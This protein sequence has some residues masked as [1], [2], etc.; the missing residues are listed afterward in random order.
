MGTVAIVDDHLEEARALERVLRELDTSV[1]IVLFNNVRD[2]ENASL[3]GGFPEALFVDVQLSEQEGALTG[4]DAV[5][6]LRD[7]GF[8]GQVVYMSGYDAYHTSVYRT[9]HIG[10]LRKPFTRKDV[11]ET[12]GRLVES[13]ERSLNEPLVFHASGRDRVVRPSEIRYL[14]SSLRLLHVHGV[15][16]DFEV[17][18]RLVSIL[19][20]L[21]RQFVRCHQSFAVNLDHVK[22]MT[23]SG[24]RLDDGSLVPVSRRYRSVARAELLAHVRAG[25]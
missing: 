24:F 6:R 19:E 11:A 21:P 14:E 10:Y 23:S 1:D 17:Y 20:L 25:C 12:W 15:E 5:E 4:I 7:F 18:G 22:E 3:G 2:L 13:F 8:C 16:G 9:D